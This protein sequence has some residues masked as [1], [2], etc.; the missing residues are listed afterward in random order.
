MWPSRQYCLKS[1]CKFWILALRTKLQLMKLKRCCY[2]PKQNIPKPNE[3]LLYLFIQTPFIRIAN[4]S[5]LPII[6]TCLCK[7]VKFTERLQIPF[8]QMPALVFTWH[9]IGTAKRLSKWTRRATRLKTSRK[10]HYTTHSKRVHK[11][12]DD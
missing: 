1:I 9:L 11:P 12:V 2:C 8:L 6:G 5:F 3:E 10:I 4:I 7:S